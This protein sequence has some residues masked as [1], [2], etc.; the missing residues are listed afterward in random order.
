MLKK[1]FKPL[2][3]SIKRMPSENF[4]E[5]GEFLSKLEEIIKKTEETASELPKYEEIDEKMVGI[6][7]GFFYSNVIINFRKNLTIPDNK[8]EFD[9][10]EQ[11]VEN[12]E[13]KFEELFKNCQEFI[14]TDKIGQNI[15][16]ETYLDF[17]N[18]LKESNDNASALL[19]ELED[20][21]DI[22]SCQERISQFKENLNTLGK[23]LEINN[24]TGEKGELGISV[25]FGGSK[26]VRQ[27]S[28]EIKLPDKLPIISDLANEKDKKI[29]DPGDLKKEI[30]ETEEFENIPT[31]EKYYPSLLMMDEYQKSFFKHWLKK[32]RKGEPIKVEGNISYIFVYIYKVL[33][34]QKEGR[35]REVVSELERIRQVYSEEEK[36]C[37]YLD[38]WISDTY[39]LMGEFE[40]A[41]EH[42]K[43]QPI[44]FREDKY[45]SLKRHLGLPIEGK[46]ILTKYSTNVLTEYGEANLDKVEEALTQILRDYEKDNEVSLIEELTEFSPNDFPIY[47]GTEQG[48]NIKVDIDYY[49]FDN[50]KAEDIISPKERSK[51]SMIRQAENKMRTEEG[52]PKVGEGWVSEKKRKKAK[53]KIRK[54]RK[55]RGEKKRSRIEE[56]KGEKNRRSA[57]AKIIDSINAMVS[58]DWDKA[59]NLL[60]DAMDKL[61]K[62]SP[63]SK[64]RSLNRD[65]VK[66]D[67]EEF[68]HYLKTD[69]RL[70]NRAKAAY[71]VNSN[72]TED[73]LV[74]LWGEL[75]FEDFTFLWLADNIQNQGLMEDPSS[76][77]QYFRLTTWTDC[78]E[79]EK[80]ELLKKVSLGERPSLF[81][82]A[83]GLSFDGKKLLKVMI[84]RKKDIDLLP[85]FGGYKYLL[86][87]ENAANELSDRGLALVDDEIQT[88]D[89]L[90]VLTVKQLKECF[91]EKGTITWTGDKKSKIESI[92]NSYPDKKIRD[93]VHSKTTETILK[94]TWN[95][96]DELKKL[97]KA[98]SLAISI[99]VTK[100]RQRIDDKINL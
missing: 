6:V 90:Q 42:L 60:D 43:N 91:Y 40:K 85:S 80:I 83:S 18:R 41:L 5:S 15:N 86:D 32:W 21:I 28:Y 14:E 19:A 81:K 11:D 8:E 34:L 88:E 10:S 93:E 61:K 36:L 39:V 13:K 72:V 55:T 65:K 53:Q 67:F 25:S 47:S 4:E 20:Y 30:H 33:S 37:G 89:L 44:P 62:E 3:I 64:Y 100:E 66:R 56:R 57:Y 71:A 54:K 73:F 29:L 69:Q 46:D 9:L 79:K 1:L 16:M 99:L 95:Y 63:Y 26:K 59:L 24:H 70:L 35:L 98:Q 74:P 87:P 31:F 51:E 50:M 96:D 23:E 17:K 68:G 97:T 92:V 2:I 22:D 75:L 94:R 27:P 48:Y 77:P 78:P 58:K 7:E 45:Y 49:K 84:R 82:K 76:A 52:E 38:D 12:I